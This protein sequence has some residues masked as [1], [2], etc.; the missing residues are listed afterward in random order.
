M[1]QPEGSELSI[2]SFSF[3][4]SEPVSCSDSLDSF[5]AGVVF[6]SAG[7]LLL[8]LVFSVCFYQNFVH[9]SWSWKSVLFSFF[10]FDTPFELITAV[11][12]PASSVGSAEILSNI[13]SGSCYFRKLQNFVMLLL[14]IAS[15]YE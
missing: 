7:L 14:V 13:L 8:L 10:S 9:F 12:G 15:F 6:Y 3:S 11:K 5:F 2:N 1:T 4:F